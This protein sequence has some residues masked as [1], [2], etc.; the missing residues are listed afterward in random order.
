MRMSLSSR[1]RKFQGKLVTINVS[2]KVQKEG[3]SSK[4]ELLWS[5]FFV[6]GTIKRQYKWLELNVVI[7]E[8]T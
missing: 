3:K 6:F 7:S 8:V 5:N 1:F 4:D 2:E